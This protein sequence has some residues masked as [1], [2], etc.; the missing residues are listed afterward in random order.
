LNEQET[1]HDSEHT[2]AHPMTPVHSLKG[3][4]SARFPAG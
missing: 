2:G 4:T 1:A 3:E